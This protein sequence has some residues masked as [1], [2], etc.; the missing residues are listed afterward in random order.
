[1]K[2]L[3]AF[4]TLLSSAAAFAADST[5]TVRNPLGTQREAATVEVEL[6]QLPAA[7]PAT[8]HVTGADGNEVLCQTLDTDGDA[9]RT[10]DLLVFQTDLGPGETKTFTVGS[11]AKRTY[12]KS[13]FKAF[14]RFNRERFD[15]FA[16]ENDRI[17]HRTYGK[18]LETW[19]GEPLA[20][21]TI[22]VWSK[23]TPKMVVNDWYLA[24]DYHADHGEGAD[25]YSA[26]PTRGCG[27]GGIWA[28]EKLWTSRNFTDSNVL[29]NGPVRLIFELTY[30]PFDVDGISVSET[31]RITLDAGSQLNHITSTYK[32]FTKPGEKRELTAAIGLKKVPGESVGTRKDIGAVW[33]WE[34]VASNAGSQGLAVL[35][36]PDTFRGRVTDPLNHLLLAP[37]PEN[38]VVESWAG[39]AWD[40]AGHIPDAAAWET[41]LANFAAALQ[42]PLEVTVK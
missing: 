3:P 2:S 21:S 41:Y 33:K 27:G 7:D 6:K 20:S 5:V 9:Y 36:A 8:L 12:R 24:D 30:P 23:R 15:D 13:D 34:P 39:F 1:M 37:V 38:G 4:L 31:K 18:A 35:V 26:G 19:E 16:W 22:D 25:F 11:G 29:A 32:Q 40:K 28:G 17:A 14:G 42:A 10:H